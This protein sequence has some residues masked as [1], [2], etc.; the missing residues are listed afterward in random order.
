MGRLWSP[1]RCPVCGRCWGENEY[2]VITENSE[3]ALY[4]GVKEMLT[5]PERLS[6]YKEKARER[7]R[8]F[9]TGQ[10]VRAVEEMLD[11]L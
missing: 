7:G 10:T 3:E 1:L 11:K 5:A 6:H 9:S 4:Q 8:R 2:G